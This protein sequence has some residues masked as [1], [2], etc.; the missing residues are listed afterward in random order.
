M[1]AGVRMNAPMRG[2]AERA[3]KIG[4]PVRLAF[5]PVTKEVTLPYFTPA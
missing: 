1:E 5:E 4:A 3:L 2:M